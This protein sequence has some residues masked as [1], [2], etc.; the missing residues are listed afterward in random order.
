MMDN[1]DRTLL[2]LM[3][4]C[5]IFA[6]NVNTG[7]MRTFTQ[8]EYIQ[9]SK[10]ADYIPHTDARIASIRSEAIKLRLLRQS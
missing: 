3:N 8:D 4:D 9:H 7:E 10:H 6:V 2:A 1:L 5:P